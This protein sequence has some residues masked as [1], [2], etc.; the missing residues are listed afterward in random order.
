MIDKNCIIHPRAKL[1]NNLSVGPFS[2]IGENVSIGDNAKIHS[3]VV[4]TGNTIIDSNSEIFPFSSIGSIPQDLKYDGEKSYIH[5]G[6]NIKIREH[7]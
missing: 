7:V 6:R 3:H 2:L 5:R 1:G 4:V